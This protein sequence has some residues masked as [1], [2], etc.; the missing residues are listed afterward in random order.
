MYNTAMGATPIE[1]LNYIWENLQQDV[2]GLLNRNDKTA[3]GLKQV[4]F[5]QL[6]KS[7]EKIKFLLDFRKETRYH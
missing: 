4:I 6:Q 1:K 2:D 3:Q 5:T 7:R